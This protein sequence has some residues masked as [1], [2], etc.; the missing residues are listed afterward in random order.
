MTRLS[1]CGARDGVIL[2]G[3]AFLEYPMCAQGLPIRDDLAP[4][5]LRRLAIDYQCQLSGIMEVGQ[6]SGKLVHLVRLEIMRHPKPPIQLRERG[7]LGRCVHPGRQSFGDGQL[8]RA[9]GV[10]Q[11]GKDVVA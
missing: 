7:F 6:P 1:F 8:S 4:E 10:F 11:H 2:F 5:A 3:S 9:D